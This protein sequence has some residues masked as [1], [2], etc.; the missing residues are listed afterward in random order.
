MKAYIN[1]GKGNGVVEG[2]G[3]ALILIHIKAYQGRE[4][5]HSTTL[6]HSTSWKSFLKRTVQSQL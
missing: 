4:S 6:K 1:A 5:V 2:G 3:W